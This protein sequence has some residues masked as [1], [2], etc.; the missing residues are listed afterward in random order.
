VLVWIEEIVSE[1]PRE[2]IRMMKSF[3]VR[4][5]F[6]I[7]LDFQPISLV[8]PFNW[9]DL[10]QIQNQKNTKIVFMVFK[11]SF[12]FEPR[13]RVFVIV[14]KVCAGLRVIVVLQVRMAPLD[15]VV[16]NADNNPLSLK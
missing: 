15:A 14:V 13:E 4:K 11:I 6:H 8:L 16:K 1:K 3:F 9:I 5:N 2:R 7:P 10:T 12:I